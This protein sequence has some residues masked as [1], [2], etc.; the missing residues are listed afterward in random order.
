MRQLVFP[1]R[2]LASVENA[3]VVEFPKNVCGCDSPGRLKWTIGSSGAVWLKKLLPCSMRTRE[4]AGPAR[5]SSATAAAA[6]STNRR[7]ADERDAFI[8]MTTRRAPLFFRRGKTALSRQTLRSASVGERRA[9]R[10]AG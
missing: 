3:F 5:A 1:A 7:A 6:P 9:A 8:A 2:R 10:A 4:A